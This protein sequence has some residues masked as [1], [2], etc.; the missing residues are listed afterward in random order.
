MA[1]AALVFAGCKGEPEPKKDGISL[2]KTEKAFEN[3]G[4][5][6]DVKVTSSGESDSWTLSG[7]ASWAHPSATSGK[8]NDVVEFTVDAN[9]TEDEL[10]TT[11]VFTRGTAKANFKITIAGVDGPPPFEFALVFP[12]DDEVNVSKASGRL[13]VEIHS[14]APQADLSQT[15][16]IISG[17]AGWL[18]FD[19]ITEA[20]D[21]NHYIVAFEYAANTSFEPRE[22]AITIASD[23]TAE[24][25]ATIELTVIQNQTDRLIVDENEFD[26]DPEGDTFEVNVTANVEYDVQIPA[27]ASWLTQVAGANGKHTF[28]AVALP[29]PLTERDATVTFK[30]K[31]SDLKAE[32][33]VTQKAAPV[34]GG[35]SMAGDITNN[36]AWPDWGGNELMNMET[37]TMEAMVNSGWDKG[38]YPAAYRLSTVMGIEGKLLMRVGDAS[39]TPTTQLQICWNERKQNAYSDSEGKLDISGAANQVPAN[40]W[41]HLAVTYDVPNKTV[42][43][44]MDGVL[45]G[46]ANVATTTYYPIN[47]GVAHN[48]ETG[49]NV[50][51]C[52]W[53]G[54]AYEAGRYL[55]GMIAEA[56][57]WNKVLTEEE[58]NAPGHFYSVDPTSEG[59]VAYWK[60]NDNSE[61]TEGAVKDHSSL[62]YDLTTDTQITWVPI[63]PALE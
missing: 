19:E 1:A 60:F 9:D 50:T 29:S 55:K 13:E 12:D 45:K 18:T 3:V 51:R 48:P 17:A 46:T 38:T 39:P 5:K 61:G 43:V 16:D 52:F 8:N 49:Y 62:G 31:N 41:V 28:T 58:I 53:I 25:E 10:E 23:N 6:V 11:F 7:G 59:L 27:A 34:I 2:D 26:V 30:D 42:K 22:A 33:T 37:L 32:I 4:G 63:D 21:E 24:P 40:T 35:M 36:R 47:L 54:Y 15:I 57:I 56:R 14:D 44:Y 20:T